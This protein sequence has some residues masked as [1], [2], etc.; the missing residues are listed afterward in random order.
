LI[1]KSYIVEQNTSSLDQYKVVLLYGENDGIKDSIKSF[2][3][4]NNKEAEIIN[5]FQEEII[6]NQ[7]LLNSHIQNTS[8]FS[9]KKIIFIHE[10]TDKLFSCI[11][12]VIKNELTEIKIFIFSK[13]LEKKSKLR[14]V[15]EKN[16]NV[17]VIACYQDNE[18]NLANYISTKM[19]GY[20][21]LTPELINLII[22]N[23]HMNRKIINGELI[24][25]KQF[26]IKKE[27]NKDALTELLNIKSDAN[28]ENIRDAAILGEKEKVNKLFGEMPFH[29]EDNFFYVNQMNS[30]VSKL[31]EVKNINEDIKDIE[32]ALDTLKPK[33]FWKDKPIF[34]RQLE[35]WDTTKLQVALYQINNV[36]L[37]MK[38][39]SNIRND[40]LVRDLIINLCNKASSSY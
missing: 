14:N 38:K 13:I 3:K 28:F 12:E 1:L 24:K 7:N 29:T 26:F 8:L 21:N 40:L 32:L 16:Q 23:S 17:A 22:Y 31:L 39:N 11:E 37:L 20:K 27:I 35:K 25:I 33:V 9:S 30:R 34:L 5:I 19:R 36:E 6:K 10:A 15:L 18:K 2:A 4:K